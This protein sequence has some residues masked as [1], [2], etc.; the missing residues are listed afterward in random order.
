[1]FS[2]R[3][4]F[5]ERLM[6]IVAEMFSER[7]MFTERLMFIVAEMFS[8]RPMFTERSTHRARNEVRS[9]SRDNSREKGSGVWDHVLKGKD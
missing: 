7:P 4:M 8:E 5:T 6:F 9:T 3:P 1:M 2:E